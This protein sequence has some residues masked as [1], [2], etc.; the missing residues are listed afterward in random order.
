MYGFVQYLNTGGRYDPTTDSW[1]GT[2]T[3]GAPD[4]RDSHSA[5]WSGNEMIVWGGYFF[6]NLGDH[7]LNTGGSYN[8]GTGSWTATSVT[9]VPTA[10]RSNTAVWTGNEMIIWG[11]YD[12]TSYLNTGGGYSPNM[13]G[14]TAIN[15][16]N[17]PTGRLG[18]TAV[19]NDS[20]MIVWGG[21]DLSNSFNTGGRYSPS[22]NS[23]TATST[24]NAPNARIAHTAIWTGNEMIIWGGEVLGSQNSHTGAIYCAQSPPRPTPTPRPRPTPAPRP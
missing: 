13:N 5:V 3:S 6:D 17:A 14:W 12:G 2:S 10:R 1:S 23:W 16:A 19:W 20:E 9:N 8:P 18:H 11:G 22:T 4:G 21:E 7:Y 24:N 15:T